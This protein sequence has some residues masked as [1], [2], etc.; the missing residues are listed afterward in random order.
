MSLIHSS[1]SGVCSRTGENKKPFLTAL[2]GER[3]KHVRDPPTGGRPTRIPPLVQ[4]SAPCTVRDAAVSATLGKPLSRE[5]LFYPDF[6]ISGCLW[7]VACVLHGS[8]A[9]RGSI[10][11]VH[12]TKFLV[13]LRRRIV[14]HYFLGLSG[15][16]R[17]TVPR[18]HESAGAPRREKSFLGERIAPN[19]RAG[20][21]PRSGL[22]DYLL[23][24]TP[25]SGKN[26][27]WFP[28]S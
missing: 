23:Q 5:C 9:Y 20:K 19:R 27:P 14:N 4:A 18:L 3:A 11:W 13:R 26:E 8:L 17:G 28:K 22:G 7:A 15:R 16:H 21:P 1:L 24:S 6:R 2:S 12:P 25:S 10:Q